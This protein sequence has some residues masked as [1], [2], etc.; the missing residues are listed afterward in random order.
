VLGLVYAAL[1]EG[2]RRGRRPGAAA[3]PAQADDHVATAISHLEKALDGAVGGGDP[4]LRATLSRLYLR[5]GSYD[6]AIPLL[7]ELVN[8]EPG[9]DDGPGL[10]AEAYAGAGRDEDAIRWLQQAAPND[11]QLYATLADFYERSHRWKDAADAYSKV[12]DLAPR[13]V[14]LKIRYA[15]ALLNAG[16]RANAGRARDVLKD[17]LAAHTDDARTLYLLS[18]ADRRMGDFAAA[19]ADARKIIAVNNTS[20]WGY[21]ALAEA[22]EQRRQYAAVVDALDPAVAQIRSRGGDTTTGLSLLLPHLG[23]AYQQLGQQ[24]KALAAFEEAHQLQPKDEAITGYLIEAQ[25]AAKRYQ[26]AAELARQARAD[27][28]DDMRLTRL[29]AQALQKSGKTADAAS[30]MQ[31]LIE[32]HADKPEAYVS[33]AQFDVSADRASDALTLLQQ[34]KTKF[35]DDSSIAFELGAV[36]DKLNKRG[37][38]EAQFKQILARDP[39][40]A[41]ALNYL[42]YM[43]ADHGEKLD[44]SVQLLKMALELEPDNGSFLD[45]LGWEY[46]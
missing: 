45:I 20:P 44:E 12:M 26:Q 19:E 35:P 34:A 41:A 37:E 8:E 40:N 1:A 14:D 25:L 31:Q 21:Y 2:S 32:K 10:L 4:N 27:S 43:F 18:Q 16:G 23:F 22:L 46:F 11:P 17:V 29:E 28:P 6:K 33:A 30:L 13:N 3:P 9:W 5:A 15:S 38:A 36:Y 24:D 7:T 42:G 39:E